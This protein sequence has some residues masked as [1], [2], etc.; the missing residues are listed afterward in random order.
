MN[1]KIDYLT[2][3]QI[4]LFIVEDIEIQGLSNLTK[5][6]KFL[7]T[8]D[9]EKADDFKI[10][11]QHIEVPLGGKRMIVKSSIPDFLDMDEFL[12]WVLKDVVR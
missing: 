9:S 2:L 8:I 4:Y 7:S 10:Y 12:A 11:T 6:M 3:K 1:T 5:T